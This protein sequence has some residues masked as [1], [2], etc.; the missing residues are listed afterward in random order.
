MKK[1]LYK[2]YKRAVLN[3]Q[4]LK[5]KKVIRFWNQAKRLDQSHSKKEKK[6]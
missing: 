1:Y 2:T 4:N 3:F 6:K 5:L